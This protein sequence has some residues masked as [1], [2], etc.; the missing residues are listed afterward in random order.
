M[1]SQ[2]PEVTEVAEGDHPLSGSH[3]STWEDVSDDS[4]QQRLEE[5]SGIQQPIENGES[6]YES[7]CWRHFMPCFSCTAKLKWQECRLL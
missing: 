5:T 1:A 7:T 2:Q 4:A 3:P 6:I